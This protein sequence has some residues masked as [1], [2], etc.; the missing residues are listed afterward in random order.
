LPNDLYEGA[1]LNTPRVL[2]PK[3]GNLQNPGEFLFYGMNT[4]VGLD[5]VQ[6]ESNIFGG[7]A[8]SESVGMLQFQLLCSHS[9]VGWIR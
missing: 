1:G 9:Y 3:H 4:S 6:N 5:T 2:E 7:P 8:G